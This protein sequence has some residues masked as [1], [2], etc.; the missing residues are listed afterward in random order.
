MVLNPS[1]SFRITDI[2]Q[3]TEAC[4]FYGIFAC[5]I[6]VVVKNLSLDNRNESVSIFFYINNLTYSNYKY[7][8][9]IKISLSRLDPRK[10]FLKQTINV[11][12]QLLTRAYYRQILFNYRHDSFMCFYGNIQVYAMRRS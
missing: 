10:Q 11:S 8:S 7:L 9:Y 2:I 5:P 12:H 1:L 3:I 6:R 4:T